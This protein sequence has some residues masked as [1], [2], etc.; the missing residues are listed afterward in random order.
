VAG[1]Q[2]VR[3]DLHVHT[4]PDVEGQP[5]STAA[6]YLKVAE[7]REVSMLAVTDHNTAR[8]ARAF[9]TAAEESPVTVLPGLEITTHQGH[10]LVIFAPEKIDDL[11]AFAHPDNLRLTAD[12]K[13]GS[14]RSPRSI[15]DLVDAASAKGGLPIPAHVDLADG[16]G[17]SLT[18][19]E[20]V[21]LLRHPGLAGLE[22]ATKDALESWF[23]ES[24]TDEARRDAWLTRRKDSGLRARGLA[25]VMSSDAHSPEKVGQDRG[26]RTLTRLRM[27]DTNFG[28]VRNALVFNPK[29]RCKA[30]VLLPVNYPRILSA[31]F[32]GGFL[33]GVTIEFS[34]NLTCLIGGRGSGK[35]T[36]LLAVRAALGARLSL[37]EDA[38]NAERMPSQTTV[39]FIDKL[40]STREVV[41]VRGG[42][43]EE[44]ATGAPIDFPLADLGQDESGRLA[45]GYEDDPKVILEFLD[46]FVISDQKE[47]ANRR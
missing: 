2:F 24:D 25:R 18:R 10:L 17:A 30:E 3:A 31:S 5:L 42:F 13:D 38:D 4:F 12:P 7:E 41:R 36:A 32:D 9:L 45:R 16:I 35:S 23:T 20:L 47:V 28:A 15:L 26:S 46:A 11:E 19:T 27:D 6:D 37:E 43:P 8:N 39:R 14:L 40:G 29:A 22:F 21:E 44:A 34:D 1:A 33:D